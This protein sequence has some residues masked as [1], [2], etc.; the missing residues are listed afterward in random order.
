MNVVGDGDIEFAVTV[1]VDEGAA[2]ADRFHDVIFVI[3]GAVNRWHVQASLRSNIY[4]LR[5]KRN[6]TLWTFRLRPHVT[7]RHALR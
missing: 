6:A 3:Q 5:V 7:I 2:T 4:Q 1:I